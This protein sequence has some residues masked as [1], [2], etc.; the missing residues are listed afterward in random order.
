MIIATLLLNAA[1]MPSVMP[2]PGVL[3]CE[4]R[5]SFWKNQS[6]PALLALFSQL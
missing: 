1:V 6:E 5:P 4:I 2:T 3:L